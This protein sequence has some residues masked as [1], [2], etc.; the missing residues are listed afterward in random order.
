[1]WVLASRPDEKESK[2]QVSPH[3]ATDVGLWLILLQYAINIEIHQHPDSW[4]IHS[5]CSAVAMDMSGLEEIITMYDEVIMQIVNRPGARAIPADFSAVQA[6][7]P[8]S[9]I[10]DDPAPEESE[11]VEDC[12]TSIIRGLL[13]RFSKLPEKLIRGATSLASMGVD[14]ITAMQIAS[15][16]RK[17]G[18]FVTP[19]AIIQSTTVRELM[20]RIHTEEMEKSSS[21]GSTSSPPPAYAEILS[22]LADVICTTMLRRLRQHIEAIYPVSPGMEWMIGAWQSSGGCRYQH[23]FV[24]RVRGRVDIGR[25][26]KSWD[27][28][29]RFHP[30][31]RSTFCPVPSVKGNSDHLLAL[32]VLDVS[33]GN[34]KRLGH[35]KLHRL[36]SEE[37]ALAAEAR[38]SVTHPA[39][40]PGIHTRLT[41]LEGKCDTYLLLNF[42]HFQYGAH[43][44]RSGCQKA[45]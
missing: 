23:A 5:S 19:I 8:Q 1:M 17:Q 18:V 7:T 44:P 22:P 9:S 2:S 42:H 26:E 30:I 27:A 20:V 25:L 39:T 15:L 12:T 36:Y 21:S 32:C 34:T 24:Q 33:P 41:V 6:P 31:L 10:S 45:G 16:A 40:A 3:C 43:K 38:M 29:L 14:S 11:W 37:K 13:S 28:L 4:V 35:R